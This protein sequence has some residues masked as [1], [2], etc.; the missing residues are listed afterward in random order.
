MKLV[1]DLKLKK[2]LIYENDDISI[3]VLTRNVDEETYQNDI[4]LITKLRN[5]YYYCYQT[6]F[7]ATE[8]RTNKWISEYYMNNSD[9]IMFMIELKKSKSCIGHFS[10]QGYNTIKKNGFCE[11]SKIAKNPNIIGTSYFYYNGLYESIIWIKKNLNVKIIKLKVFVENVKAIK[12]YK[13]LG[14]VETDIEYLDFKIKNNELHWIV[15]G[16]K[17]SMKK[18]IIMIKYI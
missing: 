6:Q 16:N 17:N 8:F 13:K 7:I 9:E 2:N 15:T 1:E 5:L 4:K 12:L 11:L 3:R 14:F 18:L 10:Y